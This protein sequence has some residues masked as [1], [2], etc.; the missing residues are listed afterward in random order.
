MWTSK[1]MLRSHL[2]VA[3]TVAFAGGPG[4]MLASGGDDNTVKI[5]SVDTYSLSSSSRSVRRRLSSVPGVCAGADVSGRPHP[6]LT[7]SQP[8]VDTHL[9]SLP[10]LSRTTGNSSFQPHWTRR[11]GF[12]SCPTPRPTPTPRMIRRR[13]CRPLS[14]TLMQSGTCVSCPRRRKDQ[15]PTGRRNFAAAVPMERSSSGNADLG[16]GNSKRRSHVRPASTREP[17]R[18]VWASI[19]GIPRACL[20]G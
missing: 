20:S 10:L 17:C 12:G 9:P 3:R 2:D 1:R 16:N 18:R 8:S 11:F 19:T 4:L 7:P 15:Q 14:V 5:W 13:P 6:T